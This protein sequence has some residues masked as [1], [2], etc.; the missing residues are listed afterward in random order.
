VSQD[1]LTVVSGLPRSGTSL[2]MQMLEAGGVPALT[3]GVRVP[4]ESNPR[5]YYEFDP[6]KR[7]RTDRTWLPRARGHAVKIVHVLTRELPMDGS[8]FYR[9]IFMRRPTEEV[10]ASQRTMLA[11]EGKASADANVLRR[12]FEQQ[13]DHLVP[14]LCAQTCVRLLPVEFRDVIHEPRSVAERVRTFLE[15]DLDT[16]RMVRAVDPSLYRQKA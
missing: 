10:L 14:W 8:F 13:L 2:M 3:D 4:D 15:Q 16:E 7:L 9:V 6:V 12:V 11:R 5:G 1:F